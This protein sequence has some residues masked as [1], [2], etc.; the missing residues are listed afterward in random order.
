MTIKST[1]ASLP[2]K[3]KVTK[4]KNV[5]ANSRFSRTSI[6]NWIS[7][8]IISL[9]GGTCICYALLPSGIQGDIPLVLRLLEHALPEGNFRRSVLPVFLIWSAEN[10]VYIF[11]STIRIKES[12]EY[13]NIQT[14]DHK[15][16]KTYMQD[17]VCLWAVRAPTPER[18]TAI[19]GLCSFLRTSLF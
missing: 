4:Y 10:N 15:T 8:L 11:Q 16:R 2:G 13:E 19:L 3:G 5:T 12:L 7:P 14:Q 17:Y 1:P 9:H 18:A 6:N